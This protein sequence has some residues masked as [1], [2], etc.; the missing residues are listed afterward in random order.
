MD[1]LRHNR[2][3]PKGWTGGEGGAKENERG[4]HRDSATF[5]WE[6]VVNGEYAV[7][8]GHDVRKGAASGIGGERGAFIAFM[9]YRSVNNVLQSCFQSQRGNRSNF[10]I[11]TRTLLVRMRNTYVRALE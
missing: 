10:R 11:V 8:R 6:S 3:L 1:H 7:G 5:L 4:T 9:K 2:Y